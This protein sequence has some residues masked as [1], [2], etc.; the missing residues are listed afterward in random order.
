MKRRHFFSA[1]YIQTFHINTSGK[2][3]FSDLYTL[4]EIVKFWKNEN[5]PFCRS[6]PTLKSF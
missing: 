3:N 2:T 4:Q 6:Y 5:L 1:E